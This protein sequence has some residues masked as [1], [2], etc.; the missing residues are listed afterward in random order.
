MHAVIKVRDYIETPRDG[1][2]ALHAS[3][4]LGNAKF[5]VQVRYMGNRERKPLRHVVSYRMAIAVVTGWIR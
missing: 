4:D 2:R 1:Y 5:E 3:L